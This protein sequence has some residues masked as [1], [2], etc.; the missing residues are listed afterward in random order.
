VNPQVAVATLEGGR[1]IIPW[2]ITAD[3]PVRESRF[4]LNPD[5]TPDGGVHAVFVISGRSDA[6]GCS[7]SQPDF[8]PAGDPH[9]GQG[10][11]PNIIF[12]IP[13]PVF[14]G[15][16]IEAI[17]DE[18]IFANMRANPS[19]KSEM[20]IAGHPN[21][22]ISGTANLSG[23]DGTVTRFGWK[24]QNKSL[25]IFSGEAYNVEMGVTNLNFPQERGDTAGTLFN[26]TPEDGNH[27]SATTNAGV[28]S[29]AEAFAIFMRL[30]APPSPAPDSPNTVRGRGL[31]SSTGCT[32]CHTPSMTTGPRI[33]SGSSK[34][35]SAA[36]SGQTA[37]LYSDLLVHN[38][39]E[40][41][42]D[43]IAQGGAGPDEF[44]TA[45]LWGVGQRIFF[46]HDGRT[47]N[48]VEAIEAHR[49]RR[50]EANQIIERFNRLSMR[51]QQDIIDFLRSL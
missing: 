19:Q 10:G 12:R 11:N 21:A 47:K 33:S 45:P 42:S 1:N 25:L 23:N 15:G 2:F 38:M 30:L 3:G 24:A 4:K 31:F 32:G 34:S 50:S 28:L 14:G 18:T 36:L 40:G 9:T 8:L 29:D 6:P 51:E 43:G 7:A 37:N 49:S 27:F 46:L 48:L 39:G 35:P 16:L 13:T 17:T 44:R 26:S 20:G 22:H 5:R 41:L